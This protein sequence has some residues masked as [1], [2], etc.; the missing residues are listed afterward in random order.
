MIHAVLKDGLKLYHIN[1]LSAEILMLCA[2][3]YTYDPCTCV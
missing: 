1:Q 2:Y 3:V